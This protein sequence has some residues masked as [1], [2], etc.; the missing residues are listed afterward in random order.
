LLA[1]VLYVLFP[2][3]VGLARLAMTDSLLTLWLTLTFIGLIEGYRSDRRGYLLAA[4]A[5]GLATLTKGVVGFLL[6]GTF[7]GL[8]LLMRRDFA[9]LRRVPWAGALSLFL[10]IVLPWHTAM[11]WVHGNSFLQE[12]FLRNHVQRFLGQGYKFNFPFWYYVPVLVLGACLFSVLIPASWWEIF[13][14]W[15]DSRDQL[16]CAT[17][18]WAL[19]SLVVVAL[20]SLS[21]SK[22]P[23][24]AQPALPALAVLVGVRLDASWRARRSL[25]VFELVCFGLT[26]VLL[27]EVLVG[28]G[29][30]GWQWTTQP[31]PSLEASF[32]IFSFAIKKSAF[33]ALLAPQL[34]ILGSVLLIGTVVLLSACKTTARAA[35]VMVLM[36]LSTA[37]V[38]AHFAGSAW[39]DYYHSAGLNQLARQTLPALQRGEHL[40]LFDLGSPTRYSVRFLLGHI[41]QITDTSETDVLRHAAEEL[42]HGYIIT[43]RDNPMPRLTGSVHKESR[44]GKWLLWRFDSDDRSG[45][46]SAGPVEVD[47]SPDR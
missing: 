17:A 2:L 22:L 34:M 4:A 33:I 21:Q 26:G 1:A 47:R 14:H 24:Y 7:I 39:G 30:L 42:K 35:S 40:I 16:N 13:R 15:R 28:A 32:T 45:E 11:W 31:A 29:V 43:S 41:D 27:G 19:A 3:T 38:L 20:F 5:A 23:H 36:S 37:V 44:S 6:P 46:Q 8:W 10:L 25:S 18:M 9:E 12:Y